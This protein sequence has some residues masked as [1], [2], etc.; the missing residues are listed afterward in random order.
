MRVSFAARILE[1]E[2]NKTDFKKWFRQ[3]VGGTRSTSFPGFSLLWRKDPGW[4]WSRDM[5]IKF[6]TV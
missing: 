1:L 2:N 4:S 5:H 3:N 6:R